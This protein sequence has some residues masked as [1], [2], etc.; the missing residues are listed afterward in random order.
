MPKNFDQNDKDSFGMQLIQ[1]LA[2]Q[3]DA[4]LS[5]DRKD[6]SA[7]SLHFKTQERKND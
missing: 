4:K 5:I 2:D 1:L 6:G 7:F 3:I